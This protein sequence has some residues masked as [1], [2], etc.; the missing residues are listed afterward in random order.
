MFSSSDWLFDLYYHIAWVAF[1]FGLHITIFLALLTILYIGVRGCK[2]SISKRLEP[3]RSPVEKEE[4]PPLL[5][6]VPIPEGAVLPQSRVLRRNEFT[7]DKNERDGPT[8]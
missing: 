3:P 1:E 6:M 2:E 8:V 5:F 7:G 4:D